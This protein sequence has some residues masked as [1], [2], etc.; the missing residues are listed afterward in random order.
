[1]K[2]LKFLCFIFHIFTLINW[3]MVYLQKNGSY[4][5]FVTLFLISINYNS[6][7]KLL[8]YL[9]YNKR[10]KLRTVNFEI[11]L[12]QTR[13]FGN[14]GDQSSETRLGIMY[15]SVHTVFSIHIPSY[16]SCHLYFKISWVVS[17]GSVLIVLYFYLR[18]IHAPNCLVR[19]ISVWYVHNSGRVSQRK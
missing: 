18:E 1:M 17:Q 8:F 14:P 11:W 4:S 9:S 10:N 6:T 13:L 5:F 15:P 7:I 3:V 16:E 2:L 19:P 12:V